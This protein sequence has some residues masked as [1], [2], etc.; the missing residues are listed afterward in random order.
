MIIL[1]NLERVISYDVLK[2]RSNFLPHKTYNKYNTETQTRTL[3][4]LD[5]QKA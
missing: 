4:L 1:R 2:M 5:Q 3:N